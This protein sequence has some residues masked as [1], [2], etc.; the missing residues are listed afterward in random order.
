M[1]SGKILRVILGF[2]GLAVGA[3][4][5]A[6]DP[7][8]PDL[9]LTPGVY[10]KSLTEDQ[11]CHIKWGLDKRHVTL[12]MKKK[13]FEEYGIPSSRHSEFEV[14]HLISRE[15]GGAD[16]VRNLWPESY[17]TQPWNARRKDRLENYL[18]KLLCGHQ[19]TLAE[20]RKEIIHDW[21]VAYRKYYGEP[22]A[23]PLKNT[24]THH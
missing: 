7:I 18:H 3:S 4:L 23:T 12:A 5:F 22:S 21:T 2:A 20:A 24:T 19:I 1:I 16:D 17:I 8:R 10:R 13:V 14:D 9:K 6:A 15:L 11:I